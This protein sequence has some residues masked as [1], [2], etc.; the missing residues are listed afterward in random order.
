MAYRI[1]G[2]EPPPPPGQTLSQQRR[3]ALKNLVEDGGVP[4]LIGYRDGKPVGWVSLGPREDYARLR[5]SP[6]MK[7]VDPVPVWSLVCFVVPAEHRRQGVARGMLAAAIEH[8]TRCGA[9]MLEAYPVDR[10]GHCP[11]EAIW[12]GTKSMFDA[13]GFKEV[14]RRKAGRPV[15]RRRLG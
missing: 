5:R 12:F 9:T 2:S 8:A 15:M 3:A 6:V 4:G 14:A 11:D 7:P 1:S 10:K 13:A